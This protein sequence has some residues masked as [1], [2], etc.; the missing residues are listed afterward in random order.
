ML[1]TLGRL[2]MSRMDLI[3]EI[4]IICLVA[5]QLSEKNSTVPV[6]TLVDMV[7][8]IERFVSLAAVSAMVTPGGQIPRVGFTSVARQSRQNQG[9]WDVILTMPLVT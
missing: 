4:T 9:M 7:T 3:A 8:I 5:L 6:C 2:T 1:F